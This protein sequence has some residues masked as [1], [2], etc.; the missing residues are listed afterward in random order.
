MKIACAA[1][2]GVYDR[3]TNAAL[4]TIEEGYVARATSSIWRNG[5][6]VQGRSSLW[7]IRSGW[8]VLCYKWKFLCRTCYHND[9]RWFTSCPDWCRKYV[10]DHAGCFWNNAD[11]RTFTRYNNHIT[12]YVCSFDSAARWRSNSFICARSI[13]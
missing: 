10:Y 3:A 2:R 5:G 9:I 13:T 12:N 1:R 6:G 7:R 8:S 11:K 4:C